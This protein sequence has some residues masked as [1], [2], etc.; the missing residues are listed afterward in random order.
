MTEHTAA[1]H[2]GIWDLGCVACLTGQVGVGGGLGVLCVGRK[3]VWGLLEGGSGER[4]REGKGR[5][6][7]SSRRS[8]QAVGQGKAMNEEITR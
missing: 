5:E 2:C 8:K 7:G 4:E 6:G 1:L 3:V